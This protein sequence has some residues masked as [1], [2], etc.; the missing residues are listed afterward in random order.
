[1]KLNKNEIDRRLKSFIDTCKNAKIK[2]TIQRLEIFKEIAS[3]DDHPSAEV[4]FK[5][6]RKIIPTISLDTVYRTLWMLNDLG[7]IKTLGGTRESVRLDANLK[8]HHHFICKH[9]GLTRDFYSNEVDALDLK[10]TLA[11]YGSIDDYQVEVKGICNNCSLRI[12][13]NLNLEEK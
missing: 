5:K 9:C 10:K 12:R 6:M 2:I 11:K 1:M 8:H 4:I 3:R 13:K 7:L